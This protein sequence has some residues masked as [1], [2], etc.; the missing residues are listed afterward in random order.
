MNIEPIRKELFEKLT[1]LGVR[2]VTLNFSG[3]SDE[4]YLDVELDSDLDYS[5]EEV[6]KLVSEVES[7]AWDVYSYSGAGD[8]NDYGDCIRY[9]LEKG[10]ATASEWYMARRDGESQTIDLEIDDI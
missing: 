1:K 5:D 9:D 10:K 2:E 7:W 4:G 6:R 3:G 8:G